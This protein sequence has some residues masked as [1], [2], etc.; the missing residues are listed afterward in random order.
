[1]TKRRCR[2]SKLDV[3][4]VKMEVG[5]KFV[6]VSSIETPDTTSDY[7]NIES[8]GDQYERQDDIRK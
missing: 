3:K 5:R 6:K 8:N 7:D 2:I 4:A 1:M